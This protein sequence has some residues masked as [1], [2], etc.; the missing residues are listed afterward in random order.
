MGK[1]FSDKKV[2]IR[3]TKPEAGKTD[4]TV[5]KADDPKNLPQII[6]LLKDLEE[7]DK[8]A[9]ESRLRFFQNF[10]DDAQ[11]L[12]EIINNTSDI[13]ILKSKIP[14]VN[15]RIRAMEYILEDND[16]SDKEEYQKLLEKYRNL[17]NDLED[18]VK[19]SPGT[20][21]YEASKEIK[22]SNSL[23]GTLSKVDSD[24]REQNAVYEYNSERITKIYNFCNG[25]VF[26]NVS[27]HEFGEYVAQARFSALHTKKGT[28]KSKL[29]Y[30]ISIISHSVE[31]AGWYR[32]AATSVGTTPSKCSGANISDD[33]WKNQANALK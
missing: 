6:K 14:I 33:T 7:K 25:T 27:L 9:A 31:G 28:I 4:K 12:Y 22:S 13:E 24:S 5:I 2:Y 17:R 21:I 26:K 10:K 15:S 19:Y 18:C 3:R 11:E 16:E 30:I 8:K 29:K 23:S 1:D 32:Q 20:D